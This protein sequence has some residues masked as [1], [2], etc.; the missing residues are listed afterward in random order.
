[1]VRWAEILEMKKIT[2]FISSLAIICPEFN[3]GHHC[4]RVF[5]KLTLSVLCTAFLYFYVGI[6]NVSVSVGFKWRL[7][8]CKSNRN[9]AKICSCASAIVI[10]PLGGAS[11][12]R[13]SWNMLLSHTWLF[14]VSRQISGSVSSSVCVYTDPRCKFNAQ[15]LRVTVINVKASVCLELA[16]RIS[17]FTIVGLKRYLLQLKETDSS[18][19]FQTWRLT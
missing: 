11:V 6:F 13:W 9:R 18:I 7:T 19:S 15:T 10:A 1:M 3:G 16:D 17:I 2:S 8:V 4:S 14:R 5:P 12:E